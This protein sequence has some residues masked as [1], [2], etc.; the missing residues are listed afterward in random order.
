MS[1]IN[2]YV[3]L[4]ACTHV[5]VCVG[6]CLDIPTI[7]TYT[8]F[9]KKNI[10]SYLLTYICRCICVYTSFFFLKKKQKYALYLVETVLRTT[11]SCTTC[12]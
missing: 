8:F 3:R 4:C 11:L 2:I 10:K 7:V 6:V 9:Y 12:E 1:I 5:C